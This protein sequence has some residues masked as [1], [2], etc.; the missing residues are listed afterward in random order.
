MTSESKPARV[1]ILGYGAIGTAALPLLLDRLRLPADRV[2]IVD[3]ADRRRGLREFL[4][5]GLRFE[6]LAI[7]RENYMAVLEER[8]GPG[9]LLIEMA[10][11]IDTLAL[12]QFC[13]GRGVLFLNSSIERWSPGNGRPHASDDGLLSP[14]MW[15]VAEWIGRHGRGDGPTAV[16][17]HGAN[18]GLVS[19]FVKQGLEEIAAR[20]LDG[21]AVAERRRAAVRE[22]LEPRDWPRLAEALGVRAIQISEL[23]TQATSTPRPRGEFQST[24]SARTMHEEALTPS[25]ICWGTHEGPAPEDARRFREGPGHMIC[26]PT[27]GIETW[28]MSCNPGGPFP[29]MA[30]GHDEAYTIGRHLTVA[31]NGRVRYRP[32]VYFAY[33]PCRPTLESL[34]ESAEAGAGLRTRTRVLTDDLESGRDQL[35]CL[36][37]GHPLRSW[38]IGSMLSVDEARSLIGPGVNA[39]TLQVSVALAAGLEWLLAHPAAGPRFPDDLPHEAIMASARPHL[40]PFLSRPLGWA[41]GGVP[42]RG[43]EAWR[44][45]RFQMNA[46]LSYASR[47]VSR[48]SRDLDLEA[49]LR[50]PWPAGDRQSFA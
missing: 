46:S 17:D 18:P 32:T 20:V 11:C 48:A 12:L 29:A 27:T 10:P 3:Q 37:M 36:L 1:L 45:R 8:L 23:D 4:D 6:R 14:R 50:G 44:F 39:T 21:S 24:W 9:D 40:G 35:G 42:V 38:W 34:R 28:V 43:H 26:L 16:I 47:L 49:S 31:R 41:P 7:T 5:R 19:H 13:Q 22:A 33:L 15:R 2:T 25:E 30:I